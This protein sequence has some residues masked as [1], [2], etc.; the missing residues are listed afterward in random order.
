MPLIPLP[1][2]LQETASLLRQQDA[3]A[4]LGRNLLAKVNESA[5]ARALYP[6][7]QGPALAAGRADLRPGRVWLVSQGCPAR[8]AGTFAIRQLSQVDRHHDRPHHSFPL[9]LAAYAS[10][11]ALARGAARMGTRGRAGESC[12]LSR[13]VSCRSRLSAR[14]SVS[15]QFSTSSPCRLGLD[16]KRSSHIQSDA[17]FSLRLVACFRSHRRALRTSESE[18][19]FQRMWLRAGGL[20]RTL[21]SLSCWSLRLLLARARSGARTP[22]F[23]SRSTS[24]TKAQAL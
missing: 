9:V 21:F 1:R 7:S 8:D 18:R 22:R 3:I 12:G 19:V 20:M 5:I 2:A 24:P 23:H 11:A 16:D 6:R 10:G 17:K 4:S 15:R 14:I 13:M